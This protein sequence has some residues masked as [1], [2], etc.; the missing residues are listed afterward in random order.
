MGCNDKIKQ[1]CKKIPSTCVNFEA[2]VPEFSSLIEEE[3][4]SIEEVAIDIYGVIE[5]IKEELALEEITSEC[6]ELPTII[7]TK[8]LF[9]LMMDK[10]CEQQEQI[11]TL[12]Q[13]QQEQQ[14]AIEALQ[15]NNCP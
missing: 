7:D 8:I 4:I 15:N 5:G 12:I 3:C 6:I 9:Q 13:T 1:R 11:N 14:T 2:Q 10:I